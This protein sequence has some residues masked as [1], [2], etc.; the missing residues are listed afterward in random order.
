MVKLWPQRQP[1]SPPVRSGEGS[2]G[3][4]TKLALCLLHLVVDVFL[5]GPPRQIPATGRE[6]IDTNVEPREPEVL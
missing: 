6:F 5:D 2:N 1:D 3:N 4:G